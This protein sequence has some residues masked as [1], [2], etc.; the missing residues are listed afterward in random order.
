MQCAVIEFAR[1]VLGVYRRACESCHGKFPHPNDHANIWDGRLAWIDFTHPE[2]SP[3]L[4]AHLTKPFGRGLTNA[5]NGK[6][7]PL[8]ANTADA[9]YQAM[10]KAIDIG[11]Q[12]MLATPEADMPGFKG[13]KKE[14]SESELAFEAERAKKK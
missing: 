6:L 5:V 9:D 14:F 13:V 3:V 10:L 2:L 12:L 7:S 11:K 1:D 4:T 8:F